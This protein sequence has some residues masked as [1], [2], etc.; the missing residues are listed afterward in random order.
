MRRET[1]DLQSTCVTAAEEMIDACV[2]T[3][4]AFARLQQPPP[5]ISL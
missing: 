5:A 3:E 1:V 4:N 2:G